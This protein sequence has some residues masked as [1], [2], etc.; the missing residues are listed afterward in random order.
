MNST[1]LASDFVAERYV[2]L[3]S[4]TYAFHPDTLRC[5]FGCIYSTLCRNTM[6]FYHLSWHIYGVLI[7][8]SLSNCRPAVCLD[9]HSVKSNN[10]VRKYKGA[11]KLNHF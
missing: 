2:S 7:Y 5:T 8:L 4:E 1:I 6:Q 10:G 3:C 9:V 11:E